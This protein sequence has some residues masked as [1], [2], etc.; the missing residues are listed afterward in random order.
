M[1]QILL[2]ELLINNL[3]PIR[4][5]LMNPLF[6]VLFTFLNNNKQLKL[7]DMC[8]NK[9]KLN[10]IIKNLSLLST[11]QI[12]EFDYE[13][14][15]YEMILHDDCDNR[16]F[17]RLSHVIC[18]LFF[19]DKSLRYIESHYRTLTQIPSL[20]QDLKAS[21]IRVFL[22]AGHGPCY[23]PKKYSNINRINLKSYPNKNNIKILSSQPYGRLASTYLPTLYS[24]IFNDE[25]ASLFSKA[26]WCSES[27]K[28][29]DIIENLLNFLFFYYEY[30]NIVY[31]DKNSTEI[32]YEKWKKNQFSFHNKH[33]KQLDDASEAYKSTI[34]DFV[35]YNYLNPPKDTEVSF[36][37]NKSTEE[38]KGIIEITEN[39]KETNDYM[40]FINRHNIKNNKHKMGLGL[41]AVYGAD[42]ISIPKNVN[43]ITK[44]NKYLEYKYGMLEQGLRLNI[45][46][47]VNVIYQV[48]NIKKDEKVII[49]LNQC[50]GV[51]NDDI[52]DEWN[53]IKDL[54]P[55]KRN[56]A[57]KL[58][59]NSQETGYSTIV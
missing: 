1:V 22:I 57:Y 29:F 44:Y 15:M 32:K 3:N 51:S 25:N 4:N 55:T 59:M 28:D 9:L 17:K 52:G 58:R 46:D 41:E 40:Q 50:R 27:K 45:S 11:K 16:K 26:L 37:V 34:F 5:S 19:P 48:G 47:I 35:K 54:S 33:Y 39:T 10:D 23:T 38:M 36:M 18:N 6:Q 2:F 24:K 56:E 42:Y 43:E 7:L 13:D 31:E 53:T 12:L 49:L 14:L 30:N 8:E 20:R 21:K